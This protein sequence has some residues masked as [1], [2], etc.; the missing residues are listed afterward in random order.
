MTM[1]LKQEDAKIKKA[2]EALGDS[3]PH[4]GRR[5]G[6]SRFSI[7]KTTDLLLSI[8]KG[9]KE[10][11]KKTGEIIFFAGTDGSVDTSQLAFETAREATKQIDGHV[12]FID[13]SETLEFLHI[14]PLNEFLHAAP[15]TRSPFTIPADTNVFCAALQG[16]GDNMNSK[17]LDSLFKKLKTHF[18]LIVISSNSALTN[19]SVIMM[20]HIDAAII[21]AKA[22]STREPVAKQLKKILE[23]NA[24][25]ILGAVLTNR[26][27]YIPNWL[28]KI[29]YKS[30]S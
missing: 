17:I 24:V 28:Y 1:S 27:Y 4:S 26:R 7:K 3:E 16:L 8:Q 18:S 6:K 14:M 15:N 13:I 25:P 5:Y 2:L 22:D 12:L 10:K 20:D 11:T 23:S 29:L 19:G 9:L 21:V 30:G